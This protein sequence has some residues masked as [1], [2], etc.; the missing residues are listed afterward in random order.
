M[1]LPTIGRQLGLMLLAGMA[2]M[3]L[4]R[5]IAS[6][7]LD[8]EA[9][10]RL[11]RQE[12]RWEALARRLEASTPAPPSCPGVAAQDVA[13]TREDLRRMLQEELRTALA[14]VPAGEPEAKKPE[15]APASPESLALQAEAH[16][17]MDARLASGRWGNAQREELRAYRQRLT[18]AQYH[19][20]FKKLAVEV[21]SQRLRVE[22]TDGP[23]F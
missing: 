23:P 9:L 11:E 12:A 18:G 20:L 10:R 6:A 14:C 5:W 1:S 8:E 15:A 16:Q 2:G 17:W 3:G 19:E 13:A 21:N 22:T 7:P 4:A